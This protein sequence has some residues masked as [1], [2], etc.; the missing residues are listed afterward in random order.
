MSQ[1]AT[2]TPVPARASGRVWTTV[3]GKLTIVRPM[4]PRRAISSR[5]G[6]GGRSPGRWRLPGR[7]VSR[8][9][10][11]DGRS[12]AWRRG[13]GP[14]GHRLL[15]RDGVDDARLDQGGADEVGALAD[16]GRAEA[17]PGPGEGVPG[18]RD[19]G[20]S[21][22]RHRGEHLDRVAGR[23]GEAAAGGGGDRGQDQFA[24]SGTAP[25]V[26]A[27]QPF[28]PG[29]LGHELHGG[30]AV[31]DHREAV[32]ADQGQQE[33]DV[34]RERIADHDVV[35]APDQAGQG[36]QGLQGAPDSPRASC[37]RTAMPSSRASSAIRR[38]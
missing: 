15:V 2:F 27:G 7:G 36:A 12:N 32:G 9:T 18:D 33:L 31:V 37:Q 23:R 20:R 13:C 29:Q 16:A 19:A 22:D 28:A 17:G 3:E 5:G 14:G 30:R 38:S 1:T 25:A 35:R 10:R 26:P 21:L 34:T 6:P 11:G 4:G 24:R 8:R